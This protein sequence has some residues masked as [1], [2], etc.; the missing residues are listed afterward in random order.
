MFCFNIL[1]I[2]PSYTITYLNSCLCYI[3]TAQNAMLPRFLNSLKNII[4]EVYLS[5]ISNKEVTLLAI[6]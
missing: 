3:G 2:E 1:P 6:D 4:F 5:K